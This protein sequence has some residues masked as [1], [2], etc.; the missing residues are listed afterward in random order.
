MLPTA[1]PGTAC[2]PG[3]FQSCHPKRFPT[4]KKRLSQSG[5]ASN[6]FFKASFQSDSR[7]LLSKL[8]CKK[9][10]QTPPPQKQMSCYAPQ[11]CA[12][13]C[14][15][16]LLPESFDSANV[17][18]KN[19]PKAILQSRYRW[20][21]NCY[22]WPGKL[23]PKAASQ[24]YSRNR[25][26]SFAAT[27]RQCYFNAAKF[28]PMSESCS[29]KHP[30]KAVAPKRLF[31]RTTLHTC[32]SQ[33]PPKAAPKVA[34]KAAVLQSCCEKLLLKA[35]PQSWSCNAPQRCARSRSSMLLPRKILKS[36]FPKRAI[37]QLVYPDGS[38]K[39]FCDAAPER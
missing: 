26:L 23:F 24:S 34:P 35:S 5:S 8:P 32:S 9:A 15:P 20:P 13:S 4:P 7:K 2:T 6:L 30:C 25:K 22:S 29:S 1:V 37:L 36:C 12:H 10:P 17:F 31:P 27:V 38:S 39:L 28:F 11:R 3:V 19:V 33:R 16:K 14:P 21:Q 18:T